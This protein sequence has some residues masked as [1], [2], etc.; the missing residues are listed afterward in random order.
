MRSFII[1]EG[2]TMIKT[3]KI[4]LEKKNMKIEKQFIDTHQI[5][6]NLAQPSLVK[7]K[8]NKKLMAS[9]KFDRYTINSVAN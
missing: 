1:I 2:I 7:E 9:I 3:Q 4:N 8:N 5:E 6:C